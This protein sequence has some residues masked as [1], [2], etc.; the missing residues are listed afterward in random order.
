MEYLFRRPK[1]PHRVPNGSFRCNICS[2]GPSHLIGYPRERFGGISVRK[3]LATSQGTQGI[4][5]VEYL[6]GRPQSPHR[7][8]KGSF[9][10]NMLWERKGGVLNRAFT[11]FVRK[12]VIASDIR[13]LI[14]MKSVRK[15]T[16]FF[17]EK[18]PQTFLSLVN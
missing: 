9:R 5:S 10:W 7:V 12:L 8:P 4:V 13:T 15:T 3:A 16:V 6:F 2:E 14:V 1:S 18:P 17:N 11:V